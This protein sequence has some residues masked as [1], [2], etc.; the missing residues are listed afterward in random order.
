MKR[1]LIFLAIVLLTFLSSCKKES[2]IERNL[3]S[4]GGE[5]NISRWYNKY[6]IYET[7]GTDDYYNCG[8]IKFNKDGTGVL[9]LTMDGELFADAFTYTN[10]SNSI[11][12]YYNSG[13]DPEVFNLDWKKNSFRMFYYTME[14]VFDFDG[15]YFNNYND[16]QVTCDKK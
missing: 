6:S 12:I 13:G 11:K 8:T 5:W 15:N 2:K 3:W 1:P 14:D 7:Q 4:K 10:T 16:L 9:T